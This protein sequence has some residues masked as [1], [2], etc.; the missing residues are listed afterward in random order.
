[1]DDDTE[2][3]AH[4][5][6]RPQAIFF[7]LPLRP[8]P[9]AHEPQAR[10]AFCDVLENGIAHRKRMGA[11]GERLQRLLIWAAGAV[12]IWVAVERHLVHH[13]EDLLEG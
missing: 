6:S 5:F 1:M 12:W 8:P 4:S 10:R 13:P 9:G 11:P 7:V 2:L 3:D